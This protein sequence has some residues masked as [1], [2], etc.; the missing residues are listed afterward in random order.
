MTLRSFVLQCCPLQ[1]RRYVGWSEEGSRSP[2]TRHSVGNVPYLLHYWRFG[3][4]GRET[5][6]LDQILSAMDR[7]HTKHK[8]TQYVFL[9]VSF[10]SSSQIN[11][12]EG[13]EK[14]LQSNRR[15]PTCTKHSSQ[16]RAFEDAGS[17]HSWER[18]PQTL[19]ATQL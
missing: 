4:G 9:N 3:D 5:Y 8:E 2:W 15:S 14:V 1:S 12:P 17:R 10:S 6:F 11:K 19:K 7:H 16:D 13:D 18:R